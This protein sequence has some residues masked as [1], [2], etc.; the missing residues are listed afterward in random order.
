MQWWHSD[1]AG[2]EAQFSSS[3][4][5]ACGRVN[6][7]PESRSHAP[8][9]RRSVG[10]RPASV[11]DAVWCWS[12]VSR[13]RT[14]WCYQKL[15]SSTFTEVR[16]SAWALIP[17]V[18]QKLTTDSIHK[19]PT[20]TDPHPQNINTQIYEIRQYC[21]RSRVAAFSLY[22]ESN[23]IQIQIH[24]HSHKII[25]Y[26]IIGNT[27]NRERGIRKRNSQKMLSQNS[28]PP[29]KSYVSLLYRQRRREIEL[30]HVENGDI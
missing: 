11:F 25:S 26:T 8:I 9:F 21:L 10:E 3:A 19:L 22:G 24:S 20:L 7:A 13:R 15:I 18:V 16:N 30:I 23:N 1:D 27:E 17:I 4:F 14:L 12:F 28:Q 2:D 6:G 5:G 29:N